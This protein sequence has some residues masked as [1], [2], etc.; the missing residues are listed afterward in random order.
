M[1]TEAPNFNGNYPLAGERIGPAWREMW[2]MLDQITWLNA[3]D[4]AAVVAP[5]HDIKPMTVKNI[6]RQARESGVLDQ[7]LRVPAGRRR[8]SAHY[9]VSEQGARWV[10][11]VN[12]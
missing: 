4:I 1:D 10:S 11:E 12:S 3:G 9:R 6:L 2:K 5:K 8:E 7:S